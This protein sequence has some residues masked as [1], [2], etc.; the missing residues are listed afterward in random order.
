M[1]VLL[2]D[3]LT[4]QIHSPPPFPRPSFQ[5]TPAPPHPSA[6]FVTGPPLLTS[7]FTH[8]TSA[9]Y[10]FIILHHPVTSSPHPSPAPH[11][12]QHTFLS[13]PHF[14]PLPPHPHL[15]LAVILSDQHVLVLRQ[16]LPYTTNDKVQAYHVS[17]AT[18]ALSTFCKEPQSCT[19]LNGREP[20]LPLSPLLTLHLA[21]RTSWQIGELRCPS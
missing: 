2:Q 7:P 9:R 14:P 1:L 5:S 6:R 13:T 12:P 3:S 11:P 17:A 10:L 16:V 20:P 8:P 21:A 4:L 18:G 15:H 19:N